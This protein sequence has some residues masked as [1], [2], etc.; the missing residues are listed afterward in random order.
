MSNG[1]KFSLHASIQN[2]PGEQRAAAQ[3]RL[4]ALEQAL[5]ASPHQVRDDSRLAF[6]YAAQK[7]DRTASC[8]ANEMALVDH[9][10]QNTRYAETIQDDMRSLANTIKEHHD[11]MA[12]NQ[13]WDSV[14]KI[15]PVVLKLRAMEEL[16]RDH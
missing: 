2:L 7:T 3:E 8:V 1:S 13:V 12:W 4:L 6:V 9:L 16:C 14:K 5:S 11:T 15:G 10:H